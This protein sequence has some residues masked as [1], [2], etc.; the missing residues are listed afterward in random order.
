MQPETFFL[1]VNDWVPNNAV[2]P[3]L[4]YRGAIVPNGGS[5]TAAV[6]EALFQKNGWPAHWRNGIYDY[7]HY[8]SHAHEVLGF[9]AGEACLVL[10]GP[11]GRKITVNAGDVVVLPAGTG[12]CRLSASSDFL[13]VGAYPP[14]QEPDICRDAPTA[15]MLSA[16]ARVT[17]PESDPVAGHD[18]ILPRLWAAGKR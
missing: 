16:M 6:F 8:H 2:L 3:V 18:G 12:H 1:P 5:D 11:A 15:A 10:G 13:A 9:A 4:Y 7:H 14:K 17:F